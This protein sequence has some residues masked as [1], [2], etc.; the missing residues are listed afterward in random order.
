MYRLS[1]SIEYE[2]SFHKISKK[3]PLLAI[4]IQKKVNEI[5][6]SPEH[7]K[8]LRNEFKGYRRVHFGSYVLIYRIKDDVVELITIDHHDFAY[9]KL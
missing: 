8:P 9:K 4:A 7:Y 5:V 6:L 1:P 2:K 3:N